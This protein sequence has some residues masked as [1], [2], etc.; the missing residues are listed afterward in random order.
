MCQGKWRCKA[1]SYT[2]PKMIDF[3]EEDLRGQLNIKTRGSRRDNFNVVRGKF[4]GAGN[5]FRRTIFYNY[6]QQLFHSC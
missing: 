1:G 5:N 3:T 6:D 2:S 4:R